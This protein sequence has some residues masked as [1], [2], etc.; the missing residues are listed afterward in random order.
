MRKVYIHTYGCQ[1][2]EHDS[3]KIAG[4]LAG[5]GF[6][7]ADEPGEADL[8][9]LNTCSIREKSEQ[10]VFSEI[11]RLKRLKIKNPNLII[12]VCGCIAQR[13]KEKIIERAPEV[14]IVF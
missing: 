6:A 13:E 14:D 10:K 8:I 4:I 12:G 5:V 11:G 9:L 3:E 1:M 2:N 7:K